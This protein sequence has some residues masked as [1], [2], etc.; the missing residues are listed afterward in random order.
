M[1]R[2]RGHA[3]AAVLEYERALAVDPGDARVA[4]KL[5]R[6]LVE[7]G[8]PARAIAI[9]TPLAAADEDDP[10][11]AVTLGAAHLALGAFAPAAAALEQA[12]RVSPFDPTVRCGLAAAYDATGDARA[13]REHAACAALRAG[14]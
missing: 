4:G 10:V 2:A 13:G 12:L 11:A 1:L 14:P 8:E 7:A 9:A 5:A 6:T 3:A